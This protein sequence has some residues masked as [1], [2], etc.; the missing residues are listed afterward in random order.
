MGL[1]FGKG[2][3]HS[4]RL[5]VRLDAEI[6]LLDDS[7]AVFDGFVFGLDFFQEV[8]NLGWEVGDILDK[9]LQDRDSILSKSHDQILNR[10][11]LPWGQT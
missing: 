9:L 8:G 3:S 7:L 2:S 6:S 4:L 11:R 1:V 5:Q 10:P